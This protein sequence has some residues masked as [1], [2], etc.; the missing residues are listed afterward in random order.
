MA[1]FYFMLISGRSQEPLR[2]YG[3][4]DVCAS[5]DIILYGDYEQAISDAGIFLPKAIC[6]P[7]ELHQTQTP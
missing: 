3:Y 4:E 1:D 5:C 7:V 2:G 6:D